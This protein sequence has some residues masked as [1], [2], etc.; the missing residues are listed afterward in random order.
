MIGLDWRSM[1]NRIVAA[2]RGI[3]RGVSR[4]PLAGTEE[5]LAE[6]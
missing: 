1:R 6:R 2:V 5:L 4:R 3:R